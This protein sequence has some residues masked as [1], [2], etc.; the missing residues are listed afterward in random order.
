MILPQELIDYIFEYL[1]ISQILDNYQ[2]CSDFFLRRKISNQDE[3]IP[4]TYNQIVA[5]RKYT[6]RKPHTNSFDKHDNNGIIPINMIIGYHKQNIGKIWENDKKMSI[7]ESTAKFNELNIYDKFRD[8]NESQTRDFVSHNLDFTNN[9][10]VTYP[11]GFVYNYDDVWSSPIN[12]E[13]EYFENYRNT[14]ENFEIETQIPL[15]KSI[16]CCIDSHMYIT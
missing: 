2:I 11:N 7:E 4:R 9:F 10:Y 6:V 14:R 5:Y 12:N 13:E 16:S 8:F 3:F 1:D 15:I